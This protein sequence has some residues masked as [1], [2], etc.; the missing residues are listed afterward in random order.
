VNSLLA[1][2][3][4]ALLAQAEP[5]APAS[6][7]DAPQSVQVEAET[8][9]Y[10]AES[11]RFDLRGSVVLR[12]GAV[13]LRAP[14]ARYAA[15]TGEVD[16]VGGVLLLEPGRVV[17][18]DGIHAIIDGPYQAREVVAFFK[19]QPLD[20][21][22]VQT[23]EEG[24]KQ[25]SNR[26]M[27]CGNRV[28]GEVEGDRFEVDSAEISLCDCGEG[29]PSWE[30]KASHADVIP[31]D[32]A[33]LTWPVIYITPR[34]LFIDKPIPIL[35]LPWLYVPLAERQTGLLFPELS[36][37]PTTGW[38]VSQP[39]FITL[40]R[41]WDATVT[42]D[43][44][45]GRGDT[46]IQAGKRGVRGLGGSLELRWAPIEGANGA[47]R[48]VD[49][50]DVERSW[51]GGLASEPHG[52]RILF[53][54]RHAQRF[55]D[56]TFFA[57]EI[58][59]VN[60]A[61]YQSDFTGD[62]LLRSVSYGH[63]AVALTH[64]TDDWLL[65]GD[66]AYH[67][68]LTTATVGQQ[69]FPVDGGGAPRV[70]Y[71]L[72]GSDVPVFHRLPA[73]SATLLPTRI[74]GPL[75][76]SGAVGAARF[77]PIHG[78]T[79]DQGTN[80]IGPGDAG[81]SSAIPGT[82][83]A[84]DGQ[85]QSGERLAAIRLASQVEL[86][87]PVAL[88]RYLAVEPWARGTALW[89]AFA[90][91]AEAQANGR[92]V[93][94]L[95]LSTQLARTYGEGASR[96]Q[97]LIEP[98]LEWAWGGLESG[99]ALPAYAY[100]EL[101][102]PRAFPPS[103]TTVGLPVR[104][105]SAMPPGGYQQMRLALRTRLVAPSGALSSNL[106]ELEVGQDFD[107]RAGRGSE[108]WTRIGFGVGPVSGS[109]LGRFYAFGAKPVEPVPASLLPLPSCWFDSFTEL[110]ADVRLSDN[111]GD[112]L[113]GSF[114]SLA[115]GASPQTKAGIDALF[116]SRPIAFSAVATETVGVHG[117]WSGLDA[118]YEVAMDARRG[119]I[120][121]HSITTVWSSPCKCWNL[122]VNLLVVPGQGTTFNFLLDLS[123][124]TRGA[125]F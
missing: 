43:Y 62:Y 39:F 14:A 46:E 36:N 122:G 81:F 69:D 92:L 101:D 63:S 7:G 59:L 100:D 93:G 96:V 56:S 120:Q 60:D 42:A 108:S 49:L 90:A 15:K 70:S 123:Q 61:N 32:R 79:G 95:V 25:G 98:R 23:L 6:A 113:Y 88:G 51:S 75:R 28:N 109:A 16:A 74:A 10:D 44:A 4:A 105:F 31:G 94:G 58:A 73:A 41:S 53:S 110:R 85:W 54:L 20:L 48:F 52:D 27:L 121:Q 50:H 118:N 17:K 65:E 103:A 35:P 83:G 11:D 3:A 82:N 9:T 91:A 104:P 47:L 111:R 66:A 55:S 89:Y 1:P 115:A 71:G 40:G 12:R 99:P 97:H 24:R 8:V 78:V 37:T 86:R 21:S 76:L 87:A 38:A 117:H 57:T 5:L 2:L 33:I 102:A 19:D 77:A 26:V 13:T 125:R 116:D 64:R 114:L 18:A 34:F 106:A 29:A 112:Y 72:F 68:P 67:I 80:G 124:Y 22:K 84:L 107:V 45:F 30:V 119:V